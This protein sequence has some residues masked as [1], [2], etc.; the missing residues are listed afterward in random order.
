EGLGQVIVRACIEGGDLVL[1]GFADGE[2]DD[3]RLQPLAQAAC[4]LNTI[5]ARQTQIK[6]DDVGAVTEYGLKR[7]LPRSGFVYGQPLR[8]ECC[9]QIAP[10]GRFVIHDQNALVGECHASNGNSTS[11]IVPPPARLRARIVP[12]CASTMPLLMA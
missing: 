7:F 11:R 4:D 5:D 3:G 2:N 9:A 10:N 6:D 8:T 12:P 1:L